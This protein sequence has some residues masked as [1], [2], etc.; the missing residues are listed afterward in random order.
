MKANHKK[1]KPKKTAY[2][3]RFL[4]SIIILTVSLSLNGYAQ[5]TISTIAFGSC[6]RE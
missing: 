4:K 1:D 3:A 2:A 6:G 5:K